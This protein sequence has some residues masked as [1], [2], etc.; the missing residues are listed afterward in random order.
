[1]S[2]HSVAFVGPLPLIGLAGGAMASV[3]GLQTTLLLFGAFCLAYCIPFIRL[4]RHLPTTSLEAPD[5]ATIVAVESEEDSNIIAA[6][7]PTLDPT[8]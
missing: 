2:I 1:M 6:E 5:A 7:V 8:G 4:A 3:I